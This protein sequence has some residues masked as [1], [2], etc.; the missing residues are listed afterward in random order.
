[1]IERLVVRGHGGTVQV[2]DLP[3][4]VRVT[5][6]PAGATQVPARPIDAL[7]DAVARDLYRR[8][9]LGRET[10]WHAVHDPFLARD[11]TRDVLKRVVTLGLEQTGGHYSGLADLFRLRREEVKKLMNFLR[12]HQCLVSPP[13]SRS[14]PGAT[15]S[16]SGALPR[17]S[18]VPAGVA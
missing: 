3:T 17:D 8:V 6:A 12:K 7:A 14:H 9:T 11:L 16:G 10:F 2:A 4:N 15:D 1:V 13:T 18:H 5:A